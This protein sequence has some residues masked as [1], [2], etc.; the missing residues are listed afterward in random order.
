MNGK[1][2]SGFGY[3]NKNTSANFIMKI[4]SAITAVIL[5]CA[6][7][8]AQTEDKDLSKANVNAIDKDKKESEY[9]ESAVYIPRKLNKEAKSKKD[10]KKKDKTSEVKPNP[11]ATQNTP[12]E[13]PALIFDAKGQIVENLTKSDFKVFLDDKEQEISDCGVYDQP[14]NVIL[15]MD[16]SP[17]MAFNIEEL[18][19][20]AT[21]VVEQLQPQDKV[22]IIGFDERGKVLADLTTDREEIK[23]AIKKTSFGDGTSLYETIKYSLVKEINQINGR[24]LAILFTDGVD[25]TS[26]RANYEDSL[27]EAEKSA[28]P[29]FTAY[30]DTFQKI[31]AAK[32]LNRNTDLQDNV[33]LQILT[34]SKIRAQTPI[35]QQGSSSEEYERGKQYLNDLALL[36]GGSAFEI[37]YFSKTGKTGFEPV[38][39]AY[40]KQFYLNVNLSG[41]EITGSRKAIKVRVNRPNLTVQTRG[42]YIVGER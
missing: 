20:Y 40:R 17:S 4:I 14:L 36:S 39:A 7:A 22:M 31:P 6:V 41:E 21:A 3:L 33:A 24:K 23:K 10:K 30:L 42:T 19:A 37:P 16:L 15:F 28:I 34:Q 12:V 2:C 38:F 9:S 1:R 13:I 29:F 35:M 32:N 18:Q 5:L 26:R 11:A 8:F 27:M 25:T